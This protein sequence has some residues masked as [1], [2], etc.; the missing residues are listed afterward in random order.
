[1]S[2][3]DAYIRE[4]NSLDQEIK[5]LNARLKILRNQKKDKQKLLYK[6]MIKNKLESYGGKTIASIRPRDTIHRKTEKQ[7]KQEAIILLREAGIEDPESFY[8]EFK[9]K[10]KSKPDEKIE[11]FI[12]S[13]STKPKSKNEKDYDPFLGF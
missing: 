10:L 8:N 9:E 4:I 3:P 6:Y 13:S 7:K 1:M 11:S 5:R 2:N 12:S